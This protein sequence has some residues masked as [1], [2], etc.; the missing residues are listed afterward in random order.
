MTELKQY[1]WNTDENAEMWEHNTFDTVGECLADAIR[2]ECANPGD[3]V[4]VGECVLFE[5][6][7]DAALVL[8]DLEQQ[9]GDFAGEVGMDW[10]DDVLIQRDKTEELSEELSKV[11]IKWLKKY[12]A[13]PNFCTLENIQPYTV[14]DR[15][16]LSNSAPCS[17]EQ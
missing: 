8:E 10:A 6:S 2:N 1:A 14:M 12:N 7:V 17:T 16:K 5:I 15:T 13:Y 4:Y 9:A 3:T 11:V